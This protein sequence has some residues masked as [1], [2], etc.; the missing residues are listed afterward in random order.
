MVSHKLLSFFVLQFCHSGCI[1]SLVTVVSE[2]LYKLHRLHKPRLVA[3]AAFADVIIAEKI[4]VDFL[5]VFEGDEQLAA[6]A[7]TGRGVVLRLLEAVVEGAFAFVYWE[8]SAV[9][10]VVVAAFWALGTTA[11][12]FS[13]LATHFPSYNFILIIR[14]FQDMVIFA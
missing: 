14:Y 13:A 8:G 9:T 6:V 2:I 5:A 1:A 10:A 3:E 11:L 4:C 12:L 7:Q